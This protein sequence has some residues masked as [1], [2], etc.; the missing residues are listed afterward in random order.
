MNFFLRFISTN[1]RLAQWEIVEFCKR[2]TKVYCNASTVFT[3]HC[4]KDKRFEIRFPIYCGNF[5]TKF[6]VY[7]DYR[8]IEVEIS[9]YMLDDAIFV[10]TAW[11]YFTLFYPEK[12]KHVLNDDE[13]YRNSE[14]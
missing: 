12:R 9:C 4:I 7:F 5:R 8:K 3:I 11:L 13:N 1:H 6:H 14:R 10:S 2:I